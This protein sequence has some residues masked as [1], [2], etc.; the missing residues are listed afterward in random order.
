MKVIQKHEYKNRQFNICVKKTKSDRSW[1][2]ILN[3]YFE[4]LF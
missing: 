3:E 4:K 2:Y 1:I